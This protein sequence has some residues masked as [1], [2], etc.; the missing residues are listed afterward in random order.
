MFYFK[1][2]NREGPL[3]GSVGRASTLDLGDQKFEPTL[4]VELT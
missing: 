1:K 3:A 2:E 4:G